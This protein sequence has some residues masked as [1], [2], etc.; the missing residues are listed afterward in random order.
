MSLDGPERRAATSAALPTSKEASSL[1]VDALQWGD[2]VRAAREAADAPSEARLGP[3]DL[4]QWAHR[5]VTHE[6][7][8]WRKG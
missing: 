1:N 4:T 7:S 8:N 3:R 6:V 2:V 5:Y